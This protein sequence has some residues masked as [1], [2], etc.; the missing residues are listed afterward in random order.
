MSRW[1]RTSSAR[2]TDA[3]LVGYASVMPRG[4]AEGVFKVHVQGA[5]HP[6]RRGE[7]IGTALA[8][9]MVERGLAAGRERRPDLPLRLTTT[10][11]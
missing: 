2:T 8:S 11:V 7:G 4:E 10:G 5:V 9:A 6:D 3:A 1:A